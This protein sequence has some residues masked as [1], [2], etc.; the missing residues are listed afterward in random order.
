MVLVP[1][2]QPFRMRGSR[3]ALGGGPGGC[4]QEEAVWSEGLCHALPSCLNIWMCSACLIRIEQNWS[5]FL[6]PVQGGPSCLAPCAGY[7]T[8]ARRLAWALGGAG[9]FLKLRNTRKWCFRG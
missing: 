2:E 3:L 6:R 4:P 8:E 9:R 5:L 7:G 1:E